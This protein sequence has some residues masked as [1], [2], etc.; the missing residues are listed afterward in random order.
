MPN[1]S[2]LQAL[3]LHLHLHKNKTKSSRW[4]FL[5]IMIQKRLNSVNKLYTPK[6]GTTVYADYIPERRVL[7]IEYKNGK[8]Y[9]YY[10]VEPEIWEEYKETIQSGRSSGVYVNFNIKP[11]YEFEEVS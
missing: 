9:R 6:S 10:D 11:H 7:E 3:H 4:S 8:I 2:Q 1:F 5:F